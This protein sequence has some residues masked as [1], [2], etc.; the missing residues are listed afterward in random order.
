MKQGIDHI[1]IVVA[2]FCHDGKGNFLLAKRSLKARDEYGKWDGGGGGLEFG[3][4]VEARLRKEIKEEYC[5][6]ILD[7]QFLGFRDVFRT[8]NGEPTHWLA[9]DFTV[10]VDREQVKNGEPHKFDELGWFTLDNLPENLHS[11]LP[12][13][14]AHYKDK[15][16]SL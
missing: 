16:L 14:I 1:G 6:E 3:D 11:Q 4:T 9:L 15:L 8:H 2:F 10:L 7:Y 13:F 12:N 5:A